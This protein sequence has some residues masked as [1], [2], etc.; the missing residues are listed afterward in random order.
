MYSPTGKYLYAKGFGDGSVAF[1]DA[2]FKAVAATA[3]VCP[4]HYFY[5]AVNRLR[6]LRAV[7]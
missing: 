3:G 2:P 1:N 7:S 5:R 6:E 4:T